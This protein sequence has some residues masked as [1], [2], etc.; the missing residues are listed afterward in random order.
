M[1]KKA[2]VGFCTF[3]LFTCAQLSA[4]TLYW[5]G[6]GVN[7]GGA[8]TWDTTTAHFGTTAA[9]PFTNIWNNANS[10]SVVFEAS[11]GQTTNTISSAITFKGTMNINTPY[12]FS[13]TST[14]TYNAGSSIVVASGLG[15]TNNNPY[16]GVISKSGAGTVSFNNANGVVTKFNFNA[17]V[18]TFAS[19]NRFGVGGDAPGFLTLNG[20]TMSVNTTTAFVLNRSIALGAA[21]TLTGSSATITVTADRPIT[22]IGNG[23]LSVSTVS[24]TLWSPSN[25]F[26]NNLNISGGTLTCDNNHVIPDGNTVTLAGGSMNVGSVGTNQLLKTLVVNSSSSSISGA[27]TLTITNLLDLRAS[28]AIAPVINGSGRAT[29][30]NT[31]TV[32]LNGAN[33]YTGG[34]IHSNGN[35]ILGAS[36][37]LGSG[38][39][40]LSG[41]TIMQ[42]A[43]RTAASTLLCPVVMNVDTSVQITNTGAGYVQLRAGG[44]WTSTNGTLTIKNPTS[45]AGG[46]F[47]LV[48][49]NGTTWGQPIVIGVG[50]DTGGSQLTFD[51]ASTSPDHVFSGLISGTGSIRKTST[52]R[53][54]LLGD[55]NYSGGVSNNAGYI[56]LGLD[57]TGSPG[58]PSSGPLGTG[59][60]YVGG[61]GFQAYNG[62]RTVHNNLNL[63]GTMN[64]GGTNDL[65]FTGSAT[66]GTNGRTISVTNGLTTIQGNIISDV[67]AG[68]LSLTK[69]GTGTLAISSDNTFVGN[70]T[71]TAGTLQDNSPSGNA[72]GSGNI[73]IAAGSTLLGTINTT[74]VL[75]N[76][77]TIAPGNG[78]GT[79]TTADQYWTNGAKL[80]C[81]LVDATDANGIDQITINGAL[82]LNATT[83]KAITI[84]VSSLGAPIA[85]FNSA[86][87]YNWPIITTTTGITGFDSNKVA[88]V[89][90]NVASALGN[91]GFGVQL[92]PTGN[93]LLLRF[94]QIPLIS[95]NPTS[96]TTTLNGSVTFTVGASGPELSYQ[97]FHDGVLIPGATA[98]TYKVLSAQATDAGSYTVVVSNV[99]GGVTSTAATLTISNAAPLITSQPLSRSVV[100]GTNTVV[101]VAA[102]GPSLS[103]Q[104]RLDKGTAGPIALVDG[105]GDVLAGA[106]TANL[107]ISPTAHADEG[108]YTV[109]I[110]NGNGST[111]SSAATLS[112]FDVPVIS[113]QPALINTTASNNVVFNVVLSQGTT[114]AFQWKKN[115]TVIADG[116]KY[117][118]T[119]T[120]SLTVLNALVADQGSFSVVITNFAGAVTSSNGVLT[121]SQAPTITVHPGNQI[122]AIG[123]NAG[124][125]VTATGSAPLTYQWSQN[126]NP[127]AGATASS[128][129]ITGA[130]Q[131]NV[132]LYSVVVANAA[133]S[134]T[135]Y[136]ASLTLT[137]LAAF[138]DPL[139]ADTSANWQ[140]NTA[141]NVNNRRSWAF[142]YSTLGVPQ[143]PGSSSTKALK[144]ECN[145]SGTGVISAQS[146]SP[147]GQSFTGDYQLRFYAWQNAIGPF[148]I[149]GSG[150][151]EGI[152]GGIGTSGSVVEWAEAGSAADGVWVEM[153]GD[154]QAAD[155]YK[156]PDYGIYVG[157]T[158]QSSNTGMYASGTASSALDCANAYYTAKWPA[159]PAP[160]AQQAL[161]GT[162]TE[163]EAAGSFGLAWHEVILRNSGGNVTWLI[164]GFPIATITNATLSGNNVSVGYID[165]FAGIALTNTAT[166]SLASNLE[167]GLI[168]NV[169][170]ELLSSNGFAPLISS[171]PQSATVNA[172][173]LASFSVTAT[174]SGALQYQWQ[175]NGTSITDA[176]NST[177]NI[178]AAAVSD[179]GTYRVLV[180]N[181]SAIVKSV[182]VTLSVVGGTPPPA[183]VLALPSGAGTSSVTL[184][185][186]SI[187]GKT[188]TPQFTG[189]LIG[190]TNLPNVTASGA[191]AST[192]DN[193]SNATK[194]FY[195]VL[196]LP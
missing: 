97:W 99:A 89:T 23:T 25:T 85:N 162:Q 45:A 68:S 178:A 186:S 2:T 37:Q 70:T 31:G 101:T 49:T 13:G 56:A 55:N 127:I 88:I 136:E 32:T 196:M 71:I 82:N 90:S 64:T 76:A 100:V 22:S 160:V 173:D 104:W 80:K 134:V 133:G 59:I 34:T 118:G 42:S 7:E 105:T 84:D 78:V 44:L 58:F 15:L 60:V 4:A 165:P 51:N 187:S 1:L 164:D 61:G 102:V 123:A 175:H 14:I 116:T 138:A 74:G 112:A 12:V 110:S 86:S 130:R 93:T 188:Y 50:G 153:N 62:A 146:L 53:V 26:T 103:Y 111:T 72:L 132:G 194:R 92:D 3:L 108:S 124:F 190:W 66:M 98:G 6:D 182:D 122:V 167:Y 36:G 166:T 27:G 156:Y 184:L 8:G 41:G 128:Y 52:G 131:G 87:A 120:P 189:D 33:T 17:G 106:T 67:P 144:L 11:S 69:S 117:T 155:T 48:L 179:A 30:I 114:P 148:P 161:F 24:L 181:S 107:T 137:S 9:G 150:S 149:G 19:P 63:T 40:Q 147:V 159:R 57:S 145:V 169:R 176:T 143:A 177:L 77:G 18:S 119:A 39:L 170:V 91:G 79:M 10:D 158:L 43:N 129:I 174:G 139:D 183:P 83:N 46:Q 121:V 16:A 81:D 151:T 168:A 75:T 38:T 171:Q 154:G 142:D 96:Q 172:G 73:G 5:S 180:F 163:N 109:L 21:S 126:G 95:A 113:S 141:G 20:G 47:D 192:T 29:K 140:V 35:I 94:Q 157:P 185:W 125:G 115:G 152:T 193:P 28:G 65:T 195:R 191:S 135:S 54:I